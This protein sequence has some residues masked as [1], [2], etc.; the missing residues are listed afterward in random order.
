VTARI[1]TLPHPVVREGG[2]ERVDWRKYAA[3]LDEDP[4]LFFPR[5][6]IN[7]REQTDNAKAV[8]HRCPVEKICLRWALA[9]RE[10]Y[11]VWG[12]LDEIERESVL[13]S[14]QRAARK[15]EMA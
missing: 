5:S 8:C 12:G 13:R 9:T 3:C 2:S 11:G 6:A 1:R 7:D 10:R 14:R 15:A 4:E